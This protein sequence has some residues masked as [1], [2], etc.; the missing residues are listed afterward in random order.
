MIVTELLT[1]AL[2]IFLIIATLISENWPERILNGG[3]LIFG[4]ISGSLLIKSVLKEVEQQKKLEKLNKEFDFANKK[5]VELN[6]IKSEFLSFASHQVR[7]PMTVV[8]GYASLIL[9][10]TYGHASQEIQDLAKKIFD[11][12]DKMISLVGN[13]LDLR[14]IE[15]GK[16][17]YN[18]E[19]VD[20]NELMFEVVSELKPFAL[21]KKLE[22]IFESSVKDIKIKADPQKV[23]QAIQN[24]IDNSIKYTKSGWI[25]VILSVDATNTLIAVS[26]SGWG[27]RKELLSELFK[28]FSRD[29]DFSKFVPGTGLGLY[30]AKQIV[31]A[32]GGA[33]S[34]ESAGEGKGSSFFIKLPIDTP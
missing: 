25:R 33:I 13:L 28:P 15:E 10:G 31:S 14:R 16:M 20:I 21:A 24:L 22:L 8:K 29:P 5:L 26:D 1:F 27:V 12:A 32:H 17:D 30:I 11:S 18:F 3:I 2:W 19:S 23:K 4:F 9:D 7:S 6:K 34:V